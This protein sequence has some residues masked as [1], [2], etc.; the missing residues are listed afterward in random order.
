[1]KMSTQIQKALLEECPQ[2]KQIIEA[3][4]EYNKTGESTVICTK[5]NG[6]VT[7]VKIEEIGVMHTN[8]KCGYCKS[9][10]SWKVEK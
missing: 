3:I 2:L 6:K 10:D 9:S 8:C 7:V 5:C 4:E 1:M